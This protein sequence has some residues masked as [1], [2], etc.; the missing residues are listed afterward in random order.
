MYGIGV[1]KDRTKAVSFW[2]DASSMAPDEGSEEAAWNLYQE[3]KRDD[4]KKAQ[5]WLDLAVDLGYDEALEEIQL[6]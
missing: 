2:E 3:Y 4:P 5:P 1:E 6:Y